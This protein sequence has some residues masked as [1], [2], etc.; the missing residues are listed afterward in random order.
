MQS[1]AEGDV[2]WLMIAYGA[3]VTQMRNAFLSTPLHWSQ[4]I[5]RF[6]KAI[7]CC[8]SSKWSHPAL[9][10]CSS[11]SLA[12]TLQHLTRHLLVQRQPP[13]HQQCWQVS[14]SITQH[15]VTQ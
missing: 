11:Q 6:W 7:L 12:T 2:V 1:R 13:H 14:Q 10:K 3:A 4:M 5:S 8:P 9:K 15:L